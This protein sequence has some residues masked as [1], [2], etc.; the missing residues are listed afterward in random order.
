MSFSTDM[1]GKKIEFSDDSIE[2]G[3]MRKDKVTLHDRAGRWQFLEDLRQGGEVNYIG[4]I[5]GGYLF[6]ESELAF[7]DGHYAATLLLVLAIIERM[8]QV[9]LLENGLTEEARKGTGKI[10]K[11]LRKHDLLHSF[12]LD[13]IDK[14]RRKRNHFAHFKTDD[15]EMRVDQRTVTTQLY[16]PQKLMR[17][18]AEAALQLVHQ[19]YRTRRDKINVDKI[20]KA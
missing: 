6:Q 11:F 17:K 3:L 20:T 4:D 18:D 15:D 5:E 10:L 19:L 8:L 7:V 14:L 2:A 13:E 16:D 12:I 9:W 1:F